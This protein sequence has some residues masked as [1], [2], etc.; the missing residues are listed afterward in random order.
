MAQRLARVRLL[1]LDVDGVLTDGRLHYL[2]EQELVSF[3]AYD[4]LG[5]RWLLEAGLRITWIT[6]R[7]CKAT[8]ARAAELGIDELHM[9]VRDK[10]SV[11]REV[12]ERLG[13]G[14]EATAA[15]GDDLPDLALAERAALFAAPANAV[16]RVKE[17]AALVLEQRGGEGAVRELAERILAAQGRL[18]EILARSGSG[19]Q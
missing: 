10:E 11:L 6:G 7:G 2:G 18:E 17:H 12:Q 9:R 15:L 4:G 14:V 13:I 16:P 8:A 3:S 1:A 19:A 5:M